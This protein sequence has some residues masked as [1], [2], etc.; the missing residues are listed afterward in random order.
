MGFEWKTS[1]VPLV[2]GSGEVHVWLIDIEEFEAQSEKLLQLLSDDE[3]ERS[4]RFFHEKDR[5]SFIISH[6][7]LRRLIAQYLEIS[8]DEVEFKHNKHGKPSL[9]GKGRNRLEFNLSH[10][11]GYALCA[12]QRKAQVGVDIEKVIPER[13]SEKLVNRFFSKTESREW[14]SIS[15]D[16]R[17]RAF[18]TCWTR[19]EAYIKATGKGMSKILGS[20]SVPVDPKTKPELLIDEEASDLSNWTFFDLYPADDYT[21]ALVVGKAEVNLLQFRFRVK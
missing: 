11:G 7:A 1:N 3:I 12:F 16:L 14:K 21:G 18:F 17:E 15:S 9:Q 20:F 6:G 4:R 5:I 13:P 8:S 10:S 19:K 2:L